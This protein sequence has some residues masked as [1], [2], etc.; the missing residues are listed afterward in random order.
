MMKRLDPFSPLLLLLLHGF[1]YNEVGE[2]AAGFM[3]QHLAP[4]ASVLATLGST[5]S[6]PGLSIGGRTEC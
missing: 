6:L 4:L 5:V 3:E 2:L 1:L